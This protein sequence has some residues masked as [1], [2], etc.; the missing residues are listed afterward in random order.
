MNGGPIRLAPCHVPVDPP[1]RRLNGI[2][3]LRRARAQQ[4]DNSRGQKNGA[5]S[6]ATL[7]IECSES[8]SSDESQVKGYDQPSSS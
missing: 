3:V 1:R 5:K 2:T 7:D 8:L 4:E 6:H